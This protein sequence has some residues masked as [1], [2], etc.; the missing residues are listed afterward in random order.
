MVKECEVK[1]MSEKQFRLADKIVCVA[2]N[3]IL[4]Y[5]ALTAAAALFMKGASV[6]IV[7]QVI[8]ATLAIIICNIAYFNFKGRRLCGDIMCLTYAISYLISMCFSTT[9]LSYVYA[10]PAML[11]AFA[12]LNERI[13]IGGNLTTVV[14]TI[15]HCTYL[16]LKGMMGGEDIFIA[17]LIMVVCAGVSV[18]TG[19]HIRIYVK[20]TADSIYTELEK[21]KQTS[22]KIHEVVEAVAEQVKEAGTNY[23]S[24][25]EQMNASNTT[26]SDIAKSTESTAEAVQAQAAMCTEITESLNDMLVAATDMKSASE[27]TNTAI[28]TGVVAVDDLKEQA[29]LVSETSVSM[30]TSVEQITTKVKEVQSILET[31][32]NISSQTNLLALNASIEAAHAGEAGKGFSVVAEEIR[33][34]AE[35]TSSAS[36]QIGHIIQEFVQCT[37]D[38]EKNLVGAK[39]AID[40]Q[41]DSID[42]TKSQFYTIKQEVNNLLTASESVEEHV[43]KVNKNVVI[44]SENITQLSATSEEVAAAST[45][46]LRSSNQAREVLMQLGTKLTQINELMKKLE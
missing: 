12:Y 18:A 11:A 8:V 36:K 13:I 19:I 6:G 14:G 39:Q 42:N 33:T 5:T 31:I 16:G 28:S 9:V 7:V 10:V 40:K 22:N 30:S 17:M 37:E 25:D 20:E 2:M 27:K 15:I 4:D 38:V 45:E 44:V 24:A 3:V 34:L 23:S 43:N 26:M 21:N 32:T 29:D 1:R 35:Q 46:G 41:N